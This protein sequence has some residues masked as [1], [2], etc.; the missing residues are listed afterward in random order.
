MSQR[1]SQG[2]NGK[3][4]PL[5]ALLPASLAVA[6]A[7]PVLPWPEMLALVMP[8]WLMLV[9]MY[10]NLETGRLNH[11]GVAFVLG[12]TLDLLQGGALGQ[13]AL[14]MVVLVF[15]LN[16]YRNRLRFFPPWQQAAVVLVALLLERLAVAL[17]WLYLEGLWPPALWW[18]A[19]LTGAALWPWLFLLL[20]RL[21]LRRRRR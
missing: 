9:A 1:M 8:V 14:V 10:W 18:L 7:M 16:Q 4:Q 2:M 15:M 17:W 21:R 20:D 11:L 5:T 3:A 12:L 6:L 19:A 13:Y